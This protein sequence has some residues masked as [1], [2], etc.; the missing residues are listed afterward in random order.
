MI[1]VDQAFVFL[2]AWET[3]TLSLY[4]LAGSDRERPGALLAAYFDRRP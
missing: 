4:L 1:G 3:L 2:L